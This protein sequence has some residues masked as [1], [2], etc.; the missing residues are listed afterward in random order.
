MVLL[1]RP[2]LQNSSR[3]SSGKREPASSRCHG[4]RAAGVPGEPR[5]PASAL[6]GARGGKELH[7]LAPEQ[8][9]EELPA[10]LGE[11]PQRAA[12]RPSV[13]AGRRSRRLGER[14]G[15]LS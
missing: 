10:T 8:A 13:L 7:S 15:S 1:V 12:L 14:I 2:R 4:S 3:S 6:T 11:I 9:K 5:F